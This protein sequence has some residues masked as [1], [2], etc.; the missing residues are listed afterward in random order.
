MLP[1]LQAFVSDPR[2]PVYGTCAGMILMADA[3]GVGGGKRKNDG[4]AWGG[5][6]GLRV[7]RNLYGGQLESF[8]CPLTIPGLSS[9]DVPFN[10]IFIRAPAVHSFAPG[11]EDVQVLAT[12]PEDSVPA[13][14]APDDKLGPAD[15]T[16]IP[17]VMLRRGCK[18]VTSFH[19]ELSGDCRIHE[20]W[21][22]KC[23]LGRE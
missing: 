15:E 22:D 21:V 10:A 12:L 5:M 20:Y 7:W 17:H 1:A 16:R 19:P 18:L 6:P 3:D 11:A 14:P 23:V 9:P 2:R 8:E 4:G 13:P